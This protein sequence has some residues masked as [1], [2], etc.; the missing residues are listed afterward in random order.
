[1]ITAYLS[2]MADK[3]KEQTSCI[4]KNLHFIASLCIVIPTAFIYGI[5]S[6][7]SD[8]LDIQVRTNDLSNMLKATMCLYMGISI[9]WILGMWKAKYWKSATQLNILFMLS[10]AAGRGLSM[11]VDGLP[12]DGFIFGFIAEVIIGVFSIYQLKKYSVV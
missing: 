2:V 1:M 9:V 7:L 12:T 10:L 11:L 3:V 5:P 6:I 4:P 8:H